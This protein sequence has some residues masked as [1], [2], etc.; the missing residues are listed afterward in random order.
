MR[1]IKREFRRRIEFGNRGGKKVLEWEKGES[2]G[3]Y[4]VGYF[5]SFFVIR[6]SFDEM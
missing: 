4:R 2:V 3:E 1:G 6:G 5:F